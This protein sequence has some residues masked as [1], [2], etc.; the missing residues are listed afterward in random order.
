ML[1]AWISMFSCSNMPRFPQA[2]VDKGALS[3]LDRVSRLLD[4][5]NDRL[6]E[7]VLDYCTKKDWRLS[8]HDTG[9]REPDF[10]DLKQFIV[11]KAQ[12]AQK[13]IVYD[14][15][16]ATRE[17]TV[18]SDVSVPPPATPMIPV[19]S[20]TPAPSLTPAPSPMELK[21]MELTDQFSRLALR[22][23]ANLAGKPASAT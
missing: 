5:L 12:L 1:K 10:D 16:R 14:K 3:P 20:A 9:S 18:D 23:E 15:E 22:L 6:R 19:A 11:G 7:K 4:G 21:M 13:Q 8:S 17:G 2:L